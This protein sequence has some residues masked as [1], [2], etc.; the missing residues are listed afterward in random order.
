MKIIQ[1]QTTEKKN[2]KLTSHLTLNG[3]HSIQATDC[4]ATE[5]QTPT[6]MRK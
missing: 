6:T 2:R 5:N 4:S 1:A 3:V